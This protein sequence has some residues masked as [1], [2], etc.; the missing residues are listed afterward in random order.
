MN[1]YCIALGENTSRAL[2]EAENG[3]RRVAASPLG[4]HWPGVGT[5]YLQLA[6]GRWLAVEAGQQDLET[7]FEVFP[8]EASVIEVKPETQL[9]QEYI[10]DFPVAVIHLAT[11]DWLDPAAPCGG[12]L[13][14]NPIMQF[15]DLPGKA[16][17]TA[18]AKCNYVSGVRLVGSN[19][20]SLIVATLASPYCSYCSAFPERATRRDSPHVQAL[21]SAA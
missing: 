3:V 9:D 6:D 19:G 11:E 15:Q 2:R 21:A 12:T 17:K 20:T 7:R 8:I 16:P 18:S 10:M 14:Y 5:V 13:G 4:M 1:V